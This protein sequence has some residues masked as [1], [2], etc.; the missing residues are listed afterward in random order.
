MTGSIQCRGSWENLRAC[1]GCWLLL[2]SGRHSGPS[3]VTSLHKCSAID[4]LLYYTFFFF[5][6]WNWLLLIG[7]VKRILT[8]FLIWN[9]W[10]VIKELSVQLG[11]HRAQI[12][13]IFSI[14]TKKRWSLWPFVPWLESRR[15]SSG[16]ESSGTRWG[17]NWGMVWLDRKKGKV[18]LLGKRWSSPQKVCSQES[19]SQP[20]GQ[21]L[22]WGL[23]FL[24][25]LH[26][27]WGS[28]G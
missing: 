25:C 8:V 7:S 16:L 28:L 12:L 21:G 27:C 19:V 3:G 15:G 11:R 26:K 5:F 6:F 4:L 24:V 23:S 13:E 1:P 20:G 14:L 10:F 9:Q 2:Y 22:L 18:F 17:L